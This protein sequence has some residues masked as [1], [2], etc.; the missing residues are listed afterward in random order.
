MISISPGEARTFVLAHTPVSQK[1]RLQVS[2]FELY[3]K[4]ELNYQEE[5]EEEEEEE[6]RR[7]WHTPE[8][9]LIGRKDQTFAPD[10]GWAWDI[11]GEQ[12]ADMLY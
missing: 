1:L 3:S 5:E 11:G 2:I 12:Q 10:N 4:E 8:R 7:N 9:Y 6:D